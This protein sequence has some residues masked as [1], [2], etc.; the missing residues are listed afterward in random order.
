MINYSDFL[1]VLMILFVVFLLIIGV[2][3]KIVQKEVSDILK[4]RILV[5]HAL[6]N[7]LKVISILFIDYR[8]TKTVRCYH[9][10]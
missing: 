8:I 3:Y 6:H 5:G 7:D 10:S 1:I 9:W 2:D 4:K